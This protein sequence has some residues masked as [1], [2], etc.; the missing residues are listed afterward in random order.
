MMT[1]PPAA[2]PVPPLVATSLPPAK[3]A[4]VW[5]TAQAFEA[6]AL[7][8]MLAPMFDTIDLSKS[9]FGGGAGEQAWK[10][11][12]TDALAKQVAQAG[13]LG[14]AGPVFAQMIRMQE[15]KDAP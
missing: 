3:V 13:G 4:Q 12:M 10:P 1:S 14:I 8:Q 2:S 6:M 15:A 9:P 7:G 5:K 11:M